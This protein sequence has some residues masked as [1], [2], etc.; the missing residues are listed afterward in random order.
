MTTTNSTTRP[1]I[2]VLEGLSDASQIVEA[3]GGWPIEVSPFSPEAAD[4]A[5]TEWDINGLLL[6]GGGDVDPRLYGEKPQK[7]VYGISQNRD[8]VEIVALEAA[9][10]HNWPVLGI[11]RGAQMMAVEAG[12]RLRQDISG[13]RARQHPVVTKRAS[14]AERLLDDD[15]GFGPKV[16]SLHHQ[17]IL[18]PGLGFFI[19]GRSYDDRVAEVIESRD[20]RC[21]GV[22]FHPEMDEYEEYARNLFGWLMTESAKRAKLP[23]PTAD[24]TALYKRPTMPSVVK[25]KQPVTT[26]DHMGRVVPTP[27]VGSARDAEEVLDDMSE[28][29]FAAWCE[30][31]QYLALQPAPEVVDGVLVSDELPLSGGIDVVTTA[32]LSK[33][34]LASAL[35]SQVTTSW[36]CPHCRVIFDNQKDRTDHIDFIHGNGV[37]DADGNV[38]PIGVT[39]PRVERSRL[40]GSRRSRARRS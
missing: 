23:P 32:L 40:G 20:R 24:W 30:R 35:P 5:L 9:R 21:V 11:C 33:P 6:T 19:S 3:A 8:L 18:D 7:G 39:P 31:N 34:K 15:Q 38:I 26:H 2:L 25:F 37:L 28:D 16:R 1:Q 22:Q 17:E 13:H 36:H 14:L 12:G 29:E 27:S 10:K 4:R